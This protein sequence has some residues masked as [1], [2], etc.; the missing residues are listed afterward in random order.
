PPDESRGSYLRGLGVP[1]DPDI[2]RVRSPGGPFFPYFS[3]L[4]FHAERGLSFPHLWEREFDQV[5]P[6]VLVIRKEEAATAKPES[7]AG[8]TA[9]RAAGQS[10]AT[11]ATPTAPVEADQG[12]SHGAPG[13]CFEFNS[14]FLGH[15]I[16][17]C[18]ATPWPASTELGLMPLMAAGQDR[19][20][21]KTVLDIG[22][23]C[24]IL[25]LYAAQLGATRVV[26]TDVVPEALECTR[27]NA[28]R[29]GLERIVETRL[30]SME[31]PSAFST[32]RPEEMF[33]FV[34]S[35]PVQVANRIPAATP[36]GV[37]P[38]LTAN[39][40]IRLG[41]SIVRGLEAHLQ[42][43]GVVLLIY[44]SE[45]IHDL[46]AGYAGRMGFLVE[47]HPAQMLLDAD[48]RALYNTFAVRVAER[49]GI[50]PT[51]LLLARPSV[52]PDDPAVFSSFFKVDYL[53]I[54]G[55]AFPRLW[56]GRFSRVV[57]G[58]IV[59]R[60]PSQGQDPGPAGARDPR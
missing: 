9:E 39:D 34:I 43:E 23:G 11:S 44:R 6:G 31:D 12:R 28:R 46:V 22:T 17:V 51:A 25:A 26:A 42:P 37:D 52:D 55:G 16:R 47:R 2:F 3:K 8:T 54:R 7:A 40:F 48:W 53:G 14:G 13:G 41:L 5:L 33:D 60:R 21:G 36:K 10:I 57:P 58:L 24:G 50:D 27:E 45:V 4:D 19:F 20:R 38:G 18:K 30:V 56:N 15:R 1:G 32:I 49:E 59:I 29:L 35:A